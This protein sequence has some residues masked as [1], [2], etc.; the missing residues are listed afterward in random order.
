MTW[1]PGREAAAAAML[2]EQLA[3]EVVE[4]LDAG[5]QQRR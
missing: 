5:G 3:A 2:D 4:A 1:K